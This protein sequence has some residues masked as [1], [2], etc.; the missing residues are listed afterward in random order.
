MVQAAC[1]GDRWGQRSQRLTCGPRSTV[2][3][4]Q[5]TVIGSWAR[6]GLDLG[7]VRAG[8]G[9]AGP[10]TCRPRVLP[11]RRCG[12]LTGFGSQGPAHGGP[13][14]VVYWTA[15]LV[16]GAPGAPFSS[17]LSAHGGPSPRRRGLSP[18]PLP[19]TARDR[20]A[21]GELVRPGAVVVEGLNR[22]LL[23]L[24]RATAATT[25]GGRW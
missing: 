14:G 22:G 7:R 25:R 15:G 21:G 16:H 1:A 19:F 20:A 17:S 10:D 24:S 11:R 3:I 23:W 9:R 2:S 5:S 6:T 13:P 12:P 8:L 18:P 4:D